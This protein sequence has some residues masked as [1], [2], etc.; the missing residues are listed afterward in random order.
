MSTTDHDH[1]E[2][3]SMAGRGET[4]AAIM[5]RRLSRR[6]FLKGALATTL[7]IA[8]PSRSSAAPAVAPATPAG[9]TFEPIAP[10]TADQTVVAANH[11]VDVLLRWGDP[12]T[13]DAPPFDPLN[14]TAEAQ[15]RQFGY[16][17]DF[18]GFLPVPLGSNNSQLGLLVVNHEYTNPELMFPG[19]NADNPTR[20][21]VDVELAA[22]GVSIVQIQLGDGGKWVVQRDAGANRRITATTPIRISGP[23][24]GHAWL[25]TSADPE[26]RT[27][28]GM[29]NQCAGGKTPWGTVVT[30]EENF[31]QYFANLNSLPDTDPRKKVH[32]RYGIPREASERKWERF[33]DR[34]D[35]GKEPN[36]PFRFG[37]AIEIDPYDPGSTPVKRTALGRFKREACTFAVAP[38]GRVAVYSGDDERF[39]YIYKFV[40]AGSYNPNDRRANMNLLDAGTLYVAKFNDDGTGEWLPL[41]FG[42][43][44]LTPENGFASQAD[45]IIKTR[46]AADA[47]GATRMDRP[48]DIEPNPINRKVYIVLTNNTQRA[49]EGKPGTDAA[50]P[51]PANKFG[52]IIELTEAND[53]YAA[54]TFSWDIFMLCGDPKD[55]STYFAGFPKDKVSMIANPDNITFD[56]DGNMWIATDGQPGTLKV[57]DGFFAVPVAGPERGYLRQFFSGLPGGE[58]CGPEFTPDNTTLFLNIQHPGEG[59]TYEQPLSVWPDGTSPPRPSLL[60]IRADN[61]G[62][63][64]MAAAP[65]PGAPTSG[66]PPAQVPAELPRTG[67]AEVTGALIAAA[68]LAAAAGAVLRRRG[69]V[70]RAGAEEQ[71]G[72]ESAEH[73]ET[74]ES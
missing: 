22:H 5:E 63:I 45:V 65:A 49:T 3:R 67:G 60:A 18:I 72:V 16:N 35:V 10:S 23:A 36:E 26:G 12:I 44:P 27:V 42:Q 59:G 31:H 68:G 46:L 53:D 51:R 6:A 28:A 50:N 11:H 34:F 66:A 9:L 8:A 15:A 4:F 24:A 14:Q 19:Y 69:R 40:T 56:L 47:L 41:V 21:Q 73:G 43:G 52:H 2:A 74:R 33:Y 62:R 70:G 20:Q 7:V 55:E 29:L 71:D 25:Q 54:T 32:A 58:V 30:S 1:E 64:G 13:A 57:N 17:C 48:E 39:E 38:D 61:G 37:Y